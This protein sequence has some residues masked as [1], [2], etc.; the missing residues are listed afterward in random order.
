MNDK[1]I[2]N[3]MRGMHASG[4]S[5]NHAI[6]IM[7]FARA[8]GVRV[9]WQDLSDLSDIIPLMCNI[10]PNGLADINRFQA[11]G[12]TGYLISELRAEGLLYVDVI[13]IIGREKGIEPVIQEPFMENG[14]K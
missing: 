7:A 14:P 8:A 10:Y 1:A 9:N 4:G 11:V 6:H 2:L 12:G 5:T 3:G 13:T